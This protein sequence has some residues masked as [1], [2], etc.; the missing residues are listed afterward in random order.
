MCWCV[1]SNYVKEL[2]LCFVCPNPHQFSVYDVN[3]KGNTGTCVNQQHLILYVVNTVGNT[4]HPSGFHTMDTR[5]HSS[6]VEAWWAHYPKVLVSKLGSD[7]NRVNQQ[8]LILY[9]KN[10]TGNTLYPCGFLNM[11]T[12]NYSDAMEPW[13]AHNP[14]VPVSKPGSD[15][16]QV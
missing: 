9:V 1:R 16:N 4:L 13:W 11:D 7:I 5:N 3:D 8:H 2:L 10:K 15:I 14:Q 12:C 6:A